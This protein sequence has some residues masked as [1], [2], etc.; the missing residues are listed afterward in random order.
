MSDPRDTGKLAPV[1]AEL[2]GETP[3]GDVAPAGKSPGREP[4]R[5]PLPKRFYSTA[6]VSA[7]GP[8]YRILLDGRPVKT[9]KKQPLALP[10]AALAEA[11]AAEWA[12]Q[13][14]HIDPASMPL[15]RMSNTALDGVTG[16]EDALRA[17][18]ATYAMSDLLCYRAD[19]PDGLVTAQAAHW[20]PVLDW[21]TGRL[22][23][24][25][26]LAEGVMPVAQPAGVREAVHAALN[27]AGAF[28]LTALHVVTTLTGS[29]LLALAL[30]EGRLGAD[31]VWAA[32]HVDEDH[33]IAQ[34][35]WDAE[36]KARRA[37]RWAE[38]QAAARI[39]ALAAKS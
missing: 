30:A 3:I 6:T 31:A 7:D 29:A 14:T 37:F 22:G 25:L 18:I 17:D 2:G 26:R 10:N 13:G 34:W 15:T 20:N 33:Q 39:L 5:P 1:R 11:V 38:M 35:G 21:A 32:A 24:E 19:G 28:E 23:C 4:M 16:N 9:P 12:A 8:P 27:S 36:A